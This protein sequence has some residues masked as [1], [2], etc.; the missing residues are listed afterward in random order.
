MSRL[1]GAL[2]TGQLYRTN[3][4][5]VAIH[6]GRCPGPVGVTLVSL[7]GCGVWLHRRWVH[8]VKSQ[9]MPRYPVKMPQMPQMSR[10]GGWLARQRWWV[11]LVWSKG[12]GQF[13]GWTKVERPLVLTQQNGAV[14]GPLRWTAQPKLALCY[15]LHTSPSSRCPTLVQWRARKGASRT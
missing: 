15:R 8:L 2:S 5:Q 6:R 13:R 14:N 10:V 9:Q 11:R 7:V 1:L 3:Q 4:V 12:A